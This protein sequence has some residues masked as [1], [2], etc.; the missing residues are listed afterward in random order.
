VVDTRAAPPAHFGPEALPARPHRQWVVPLAAA[1]LVVVVVVATTT[2][3]LD[4]GTDRPTDVPLL[5]ADG[6]RDDFTRIESPAPLGDTRTGQAW[7]E[8]SGTWE[9]RDGAARVVEVNEL[10]TRTV[11]VADLGASDGAVSVTAASMANGFG[12]VFRFQDAFNYWLVVASPEFGS[13]RLQRLDEG[14]T[15]ELGGIGLAPAEDG[16]TVEVRFEGRTITLFVDGLQRREVVDDALVDATGVGL[17]AE[18][19]ASTE[20]AWDDF[21]AVPVATPSSTSLAAS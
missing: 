20:A 7:D 11:A 4:D 17:L 2:W 8:V 15:V 12:L 3:I 18:G 5:V 14:H 19:P 16:S 10:G 9:V 6:V 21:V 13:W 1:A